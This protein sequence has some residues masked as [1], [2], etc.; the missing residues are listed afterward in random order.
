[1]KP[2]LKRREFLTHC[3]KAG[4]SSCA[5]M[6]SPQIFAQTEGKPD[7]KKLN[8]C[9]YTCSLECTMYK[10]T[11]ENN[12]ELKQKAYKD[13][14]IK[15]KFGIDFDPDKVFCWGCKVEDKPIS[16]AVKSCTVRKCVIE[17]GYD[18]CI[19]CAGLSAC[20]KELWSNFPQFKNKVIEMQKKYQS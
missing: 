10:G 4:V 17:K 1:M 18:C 8:F 12:I 15:E 5:L 20:D 7:P 2:D 11:V 6:Y 14:K 3:L 13:F 16:T 9:G 19:Q